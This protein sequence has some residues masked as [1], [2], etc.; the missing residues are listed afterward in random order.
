MQKKKSVRHKI[1]VNIKNLSFYDHLGHLQEYTRDHF[2]G[3]LFSFYRKGS[4]PRIKQVNVRTVI[5]SDGM[6]ER[7]QRP[8]KSTKTGAEK[9]NQVSRVY[10][11]I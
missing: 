7:L 3:L 10:L 5:S 9:S 11:T 1:S 2:K 8:F 6:G 4:K